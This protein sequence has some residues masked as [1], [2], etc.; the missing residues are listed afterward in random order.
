MQQTLQ[1]TRSVEQLLDFGS[2]NNEEWLRVK[3]PHL[4]IFNRMQFSSAITSLENYLEKQKIPF[5]EYH[6]YNDLATLVKTLKGRH[7]VIIETVQNPA[8]NK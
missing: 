4:H 8:S 6:N 2:T 7:L 1:T 3:E 5:K